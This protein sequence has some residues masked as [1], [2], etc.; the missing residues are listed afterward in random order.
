MKD[1]GV[2]FVY[3]SIYD[4]AY[5]YGIKKSAPLIKTDGSRL[6]TTKIGCLNMELT[7]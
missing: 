1:A 3:L 7:R 5:T 2:D 6:L 4:I